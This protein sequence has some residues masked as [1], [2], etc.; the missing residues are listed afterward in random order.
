MTSAQSCLGLLGH[1]VGL[2]GIPHLHNALNALLC[3]FLIPVPPG[4]QSFLKLPSVGLFSV[5]HVWATCVPH[6]SLVFFAC[7]QESCLSSLVKVKVK[8]VSRV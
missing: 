2:G 3:L 6:H 4:R 8:S 1:F 5:I 7:Y